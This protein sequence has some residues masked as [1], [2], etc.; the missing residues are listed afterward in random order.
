MSARLPR[1]PLDESSSHWLVCAAQAVESLHNWYL[2]A[3]RLTRAQLWT[4]LAIHQGDRQ[5]AAIARA[6]GV[7]P[8]AVTR[9]V[10]QLVRKG[11]VRRSRTDGDRRFLS[12]E[13]T[14]KAERDLPTLQSAAHRADLL[15]TKGLRPEQ[16][17]ALRETARHVV[18]NARDQDPAGEDDP[19]SPDAG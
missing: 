18:G 11:Y 14:E 13:L 19:P 15:L 2:K 3:Y 1:Q 5:P 7:N 6:L 17:E 12:I 8:A 10:D 9:L 16:L 4:L